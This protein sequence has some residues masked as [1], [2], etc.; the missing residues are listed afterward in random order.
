M[1]S[2]IGLGGKKVTQSSPNSAK[3]GIELGT[4]WSEGRDLTNCANHARPRNKLTF[5]S[6]FTKLNYFFREPNVKFSIKSIIWLCITLS[7]NTE[8]LFRR[9][10]GI[11]VSERALLS[12]CKLN[13]A[14]MWCGTYHMVEYVVKKWYMD[15][16]MM[17]YVLHIIWWSVWYGNGIW[18]KLHMWYVILI[19]FCDRISVW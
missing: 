19:I 9:D 2:W 1:E 7:K 10:A 13:T 15:M 16:Y 3:P 14:C 4:L 12:R 6:T 11:K 18:Y 5:I 17:W 8:K